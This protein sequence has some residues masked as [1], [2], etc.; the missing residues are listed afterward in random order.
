MTQK[1]KYILILLLLSPLIFLLCDGYF[2]RLTLTDHNYGI[3]YGNTVFPDGSPSPRLSARLEAGVELYK[4]W[5]IHTLIVSGGIG[6]EGHD[7]AEVM[8]NFL[9]K[10]GI[11]QENIIIDHDGYTTRQTSENAFKIIS[12]REKDMRDISVIGISQLF[13]ISRVKLSLK[14]AGFQTVSG[15]TPLYFEARDIYSLVR[16]IPAYVK[17]WL[18]K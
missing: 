15:Y 9:T 12:E 6:K 1:I 14:Q 18:E 17:Y 10:S 2:S 5:R 7:E 13:H 16:E 11:P 4:K 8:G 3:I